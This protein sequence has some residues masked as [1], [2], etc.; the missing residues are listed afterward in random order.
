MDAF[1]ILV[2]V[3]STI[4]AVCL[5]LM[6]V[7]MFFVVKIVKN[8]KQISDK[9]TTLVED[10]SNAAAMMRKAAAPTAIAKFIA[11]QVSHAVKKHKNKE[12]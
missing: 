12:D 8:I 10:A 5:F 4:L 3:L 9:A 2:I 11:E 6:M 1:E 7:T